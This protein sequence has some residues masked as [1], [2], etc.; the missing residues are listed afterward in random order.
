MSRSTARQ[1]LAPGLTVGPGEVLVA[2]E[3][4]DPARGLLPCP[5]APLVGAAAA[6][7]GVRVRYG[8]VPQCADAAQADDGA[9]VFLTSALHTGGGGSAIGAAADPVDGVAVAAA[10]AAVGE[11]S[12]VVATRRLLAAGSPWCDGARQA[13]AAAETAVAAAG[14]PVHIIGHLTGSPA[15]RAALTA[16]GAVPARSVDDVPDGGTVLIPA[17]GVAPEVLVTAAERG[18]TVINATCP[19]V[20]GVHAQARRF[21]ERGGQVVLIGQPDHVVA[22]GIAGQ[23][24][25]QVTIAS[26]SAG[27]TGIGAADPRRVSYLVQPGIPVEDA[28]PVTA[29]LRSR[30]PALRGPDPDRFCYAA[31]DRAETI[32]AVAAACDLV[33]VLGA[34]QDPDTRQATGLARDAHAKVH[35]ISE[36]GQIEA[37]WLA[38]TSAIGLVETVSADAG[39]ASQVTTALSGLGQL[40]VTRRRVTTEILSPAR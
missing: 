38:G 31:S 3:L 28:A 20:A 39:L 26:T 21:A 5:A 14:G 27:T 19:L 18:L 11:W 16:A 25:G 2:T 6:R 33:F 22:A 35:V 32:R 23:A 4:G 13:L 7:R 36:P 34:E 10:R 40:S 9:V 15:D 37:A 24:P 1:C 8:A 12:A 30:F 29:A 17:H